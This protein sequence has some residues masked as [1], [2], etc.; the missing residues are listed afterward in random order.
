MFGDLHCSDPLLPQKWV[1]SEK[2]LNSCA[3]LPWPSRAVSINAGWHFFGGISTHFV[4]RGTQGNGCGFLTRAQAALQIV[5]CHFERQ[6]DPCLQSAR[7]CNLRE[8]NAEL[9]GNN[10][11]GLATK[12]TS[13]CFAGIRAMKWCLFV[14]SSHAFR[15]LC[16]SRAMAQWTWGT[17][18]GKMVM[19]CCLCASWVGKWVMLIPGAET[20]WF[21][22][23]KIL[24]RHLCEQSEW[25]SLQC[26]FFSALF[27]FI[28][29]YIFSWRL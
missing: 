18:Q 29:W 4:A 10:Q 13:Q 22:L 12:E 24:P 8:C 14:D 25:I 20:G 3:P 2:W 17:E 6:S 7:L 15:F 27:L 28:K 16:C 1:H 23:K 21:L 19:W 26:Y 9:R 11:I 5:C